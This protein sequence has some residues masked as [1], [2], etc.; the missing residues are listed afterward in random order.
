MVTLLLQVPSCISIVLV[1]QW[2]H[3]VEESQSLY[4]WNLDSKIFINQ[5]W[6][7]EK[8]EKIQWSSSALVGGGG[9]ERERER[10]RG[11]INNVTFSTGVQ[12]KAILELFKTGHTEM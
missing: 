3:K 2:T 4:H 9:G 5:L 11:N 7:E 6:E 1:T 10:E 12:L 8:N